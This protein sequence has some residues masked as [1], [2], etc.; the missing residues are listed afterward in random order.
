MTGIS[1]PTI[2]CHLAQKKLIKK[3]ISFTSPRGLLKHFLCMIKLIKME[4]QRTSNTRKISSKDAIL[5]FCGTT[6]LASL[7]TFT[8]NSQDL[9]FR[10]FD[11]HPLSTLGSGSSMEM[12]SST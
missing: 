6:T 2:F 9:P 7:Q 12:A 4:G 10:T 8:G 5:A 1:R 11:E 3:R